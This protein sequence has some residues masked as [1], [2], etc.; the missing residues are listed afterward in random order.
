VELAFTGGFYF[1]HR[2][3]LGS[4]DVITDAY[5]AV[6]NKTSFD[7]FGGRLESTWNKDIAAASMNQINP[8]RRFPWFL[9]R[10]DYIETSIECA[11][12][13]HGA[14]RRRFSR[15]RNILD[16]LKG[17]LTKDAA[18]NVSFQG[19]VSGVTEMYNFHKPGLVNEVGRLLPGREFALE[20]VGDR[21]VTFP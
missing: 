17:T 7:A 10:S 15:Y 20:F 21:A 5:G 13:E 2:D 12:F 9:R 18:G 1:L 4:V 8:A 3:H 19:R 6:L 16:F 11:F 14:V